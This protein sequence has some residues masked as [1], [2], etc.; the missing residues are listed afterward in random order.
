V[1]TDRCGLAAL[2][3][4]FS[5]GGLALEGGLVRIVDVGN[6]QIVGNLTTN[7]G[8]PS[9]MAV[10]PDGRRIYLSRF[11]E[12]GIDVLDSSGPKQIGTIDTSK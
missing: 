1:A 3:R 5:G 7:L 8:L 6:R 11:F 12:P 2:S 9:R 10:S 4:S